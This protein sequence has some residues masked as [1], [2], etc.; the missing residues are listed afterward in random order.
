MTVN[1][2]DLAKEWRLPRVLTAPMVE[3][4]LA[5]L[6]G[7]VRKVVVRLGSW[8]HSGPF[9]DA[10]LQG[11][12]CLLHRRNIETIAH[13]PKLTFRD[14]REA[15]AFADPD[16]LRRLRPLT[17]TELNLTNSVAGLAIG[18]LCE[19]SKMHQRIG[20]LQ[21]EVLERRRYLFGWGDE[22]ALVVPTEV[23][24]TGH[25]RKSASER[26]AAFNHRLQDLLQPLGLSPKS[27]DLVNIPWFQ[28]LKAFAF[29]ASENTWDHGR[30][31]FEGRPIRS[32]RFVR[33]RRIDVS[34]HGL[35]IGRAAPGFEDSFANYLEAL[36][37]ASDLREYWDKGEGRLVEVTVADGGVGIAASMAG[38]FDVFEGQ[39]ETETQHLMDAILPDGTTKRPSEPGR[40][41]GLGKMLR[42]CFRLS[43]LTVVRTGRLSASRTYRRTDGSSESVDFENLSSDAYVPKVNCSPLPLLAGTSVSLVFPVGR[44]HGVAPLRLF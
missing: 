33:L 31:D 23:A 36:N 5:S 3:D 40:G 8:E 29:E 43:G 41:Q 15:I 1:R 37:A 7:W 20:V 11:A 39:L 12:L 10:R 35:D 32:I 14:D 13:V 44:S 42:A 17:P 9:A 25:R 38:G 26:E 21:R 19:F 34:A 16:P 22:V 24:V 28:Q 4:W 27:V 18:Q 6:P 30:L 2:D